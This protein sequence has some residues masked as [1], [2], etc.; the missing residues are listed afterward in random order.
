MVNPIIY[1]IE[2]KLNNFIRKNSNTAAGLGFARSLKKSISNR[3]QI[4]KNDPAY[5]LATAIDPRFKTILMELYEVENVKRLLTTEVESLKLTSDTE[6]ETT[7]QNIKPITVPVPT[8]TLWD[9]LQE[10]SISSSG[11]GGIAVLK[12]R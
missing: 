9:I 8:N 1:T 2:T 11:N 12:M 5:L 3:F 6:L 4:C 10:R 7:E